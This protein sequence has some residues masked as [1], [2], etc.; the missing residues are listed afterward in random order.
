MSQALWKLLISGLKQGKY[1]M[2]LKHLMPEN[3]EELKD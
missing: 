2:N 1:K 3:K